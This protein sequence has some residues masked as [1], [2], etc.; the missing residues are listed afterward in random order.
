M[1]TESIDLLAEIALEL[2]MSRSGAIEFLVRTYER[3]EKVRADLDQLRDD[4]EAARLPG[5]PQR[6][7]TKQKRKGR[8]R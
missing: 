5:D 3:R 1:S 4:L 7:T 2:G 8:G 6:P